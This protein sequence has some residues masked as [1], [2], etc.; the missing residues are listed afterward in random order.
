MTL[1]LPSFILEDME[2]KLSDLFSWAPDFWNFQLIQV[3]GQSIT[4]GT[5][6]TGIILFILGYF[7]CKSISR[8]FAKKI[9]SRFDIDQALQHTLQT[10]VF[11]ILLVILTL[12]VLRLLHVPVTI[13]TVLGGALAIGVGFGSQNIVNNFIS[14]LI[15]MIERPVKV[16][17]IIEVGDV[18]G[19]VINIGAR[20]TQIKTLD[21]THYVIPNSTFLEQNVL[22]WTLSDDLVR[23]FVSVG[24]AYGSDARKV[25]ELLKQAAQEEEKVLNYPEP[26]VVFSDF[27]DNALVFK[28]FFWTKIKDIMSL[29]ALES[30]LRF[31]INHLFNEAEIVIAFPQ[32][33]VHLDTPSPIKVEVLK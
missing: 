28:L 19:T 26:V 24:V 2:D 13:F 18:S 20:S 23:T 1:F 14:G 6:L 27:G 7:I 22:N 5:V 4:F 29:R 17:D 31:R 12:F 21:N 10:F 33:D 30:A 15:I 9:L 16:G 25:E 11:Y 3:D 8:Q 32:R